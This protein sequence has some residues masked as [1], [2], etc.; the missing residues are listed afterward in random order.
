[1]FEFKVYVPGGY[2]SWLEGCSP[3]QLELYVWAIYKSASVGATDWAIGAMFLSR[4]LRVLLCDMF[5]ELHPVIF[6]Y[7]L[8]WQTFLQVSAASQRTH[9]GIQKQDSK[10]NE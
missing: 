7:A 9:T 2:L 3:L 4:L 6:F 1:M 8:F 10:K 5:T